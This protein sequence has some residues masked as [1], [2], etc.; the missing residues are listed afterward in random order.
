MLTFKDYSEEAIKT[1][2]Y[3]K[4]GLQSLCYLVLGLCGES[5]EVAEK[6]K[7]IIRNDE[8]LTDE[9]RIELMK[10]LG[11]V[12]WYITMLSKELGYDL[13]NVAKANILKLSDR[14]DRGVIKG[15]GDNR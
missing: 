9:K 15:N 5:G 12:L 4:D 8:K 2:V 11:D 1:A 14:K 3:P 10:E 6:L 13:H 7:K